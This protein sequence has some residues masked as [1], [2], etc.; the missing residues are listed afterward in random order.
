MA[1]GHATK[2]A[3]LGTSPSVNSTRHG[4]D[5]GAAKRVAR[6][7]APTTCRHDSDRKKHATQGEE[8]DRPQCSCRLDGSGRRT[9][10]TRSKGA[11]S[12]GREVGKGGLLAQARGRTSLPRK[13][14]LEQ[15]TR[16]GNL[17]NTL[18]DLVGFFF[19]M[20]KTNYA[21][22]TFPG[23]RRDVNG[24]PKDPVASVSSGR[25]EGDSAAAFIG[26]AAAVTACG[27]QWCGRYCC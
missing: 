27:R 22:S 1:L 13:Q 6:K 20:S 5:R 9:G 14:D 17:L 2:R 11:R 21:R 3:R 8:A 7:R 4:P 26:V 18:L 10:Y 25:S 15:K 16:S 24:T 23:V 12:Y 19:V